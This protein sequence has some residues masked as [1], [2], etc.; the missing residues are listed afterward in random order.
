M[1]WTV[2]PELKAH[3]D[4]TFPKV[5]AARALERFRRHHRTKAT[6]SSS[7]DSAFISWVEE[8]A[9]KIGEHSEGGTDYRGVPN[10][11]RSEWDRYL[12]GRD[13]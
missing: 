4:K 2:S 5:D 8:D 1:D 10:D 12:M 3:I 6:K 11:T 7:W 13:Q 9:E